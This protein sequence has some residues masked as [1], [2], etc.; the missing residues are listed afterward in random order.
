MNRM[1]SLPNGSMAKKPMSAWP[2]FTASTDL[3]AASKGQQYDADAQ[4]LGQRPVCGGK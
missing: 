2:P 1:R 3:A 4:V